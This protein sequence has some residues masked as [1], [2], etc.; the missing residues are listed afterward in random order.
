MNSFD[1]FSVILFFHSF[2]DVFV[3]CPNKPFSLEE[4]KIRAK[5]MDE[6][7]INS[8]ICYRKG[9][10]RENLKILLEEE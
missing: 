1:K 9:M 5:G 2:L 8:K 10:I 7:T 3:Q 6:N 4:M